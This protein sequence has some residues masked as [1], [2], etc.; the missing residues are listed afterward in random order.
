[1]AF[2]PVDTT[3]AVPTALYRS[4]PGQTSAEPGQS[5]PHAGQPEIGQADGR[6]VENV[7]SGPPWQR[8]M[9]VL[10]QAWSDSRHAPVV[11]SVEGPP[12]VGKSALLAYFLEEIAPAAG[13]LNVQSVDAMAPPPGEVDPSAAESVE[14]AVRRGTGARTPDE[15]ASERRTVRVVAASGASDS[16]DDWI[17]SRLLP[18]LGPGGLG[19]VE[20]QTFDPLPEV[21]AQPLPIRRLVLD[22]WEPA[23]AAAYLAHRGM[24]PTWIPWAVEIGAG[25]PAWPTPYA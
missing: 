11:V 14:I 25:S 8:A 2:S 3:D 6:P 9:E 17:R 4:R 16:T 7:W 10:R 20:R 23:T 1:M 12:G 18:A 13:R 19:L 24:P 15:P 22:R 5:A 21:A